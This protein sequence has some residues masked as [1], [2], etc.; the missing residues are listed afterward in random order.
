MIIAASQ[1]PVTADI[2]R[3]FLFIQRQLKQA[4]ARNATV[5][6]F[7]ET[8]LSGYAPKHIPEMSNF[9]WSQLQSYTQRICELANDL[10]MWVVLG[11]M[12]Q[13]LG[14]LPTSCL[15]IISSDGDI[16]ATYAK[17]RL[18]GNEVDYFSTGESACVVNIEGFR[19][20][21]LVCYDNCF[22]E[23]YNTY[24]DLGVELLFHSFY[25]AK[26]TKPTPIADLMAANLIVR[27]AD[28]G[29]WISASNS[30]ERYSPLCASIVRPDGQQ[31]KATRHKTT[32]VFEQFPGDVG[33]TYDNRQS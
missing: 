4:A 7:P 26:N 28:N 29:M 32:L 22:P 13:L 16:V 5:V 1:F 19:C 8:A 33:W 31:T 14:R 27:A 12:E 25:N 3:N 11:S 24:R 9:D 10:E 2:N 6:Q 18:Y 17:Q 20:G 15:H 23:L 30:S 21:F